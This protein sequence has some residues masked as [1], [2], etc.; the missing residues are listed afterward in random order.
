M[1]HPERKIKKKLG[2]E[3][4][5]VGARG[6]SVIDY[7]MVNDNICDRIVKFRID[8]RVNSDHMPLSL[9][10]EEGTDMGLEEDDAEQDRDEEDKD[11][12]EEEIIVWNKETIKSYI[13]NTEVINDAEDI[14][15]GRRNNEKEI[16][17]MWEELKQMVFNNVVKKKIKRKRRCIGYKDFLV[18]YKLL[19][20]EERSEENMK[21]MEK[22]KKDEKKMFGEEERELLEKKQKEKREEEEEELKKLKR[23]ADV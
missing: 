2:E 16:E 18:G 6:I 19:Q 9:I 15:K 20:E 10:L 13:K 22:W 5:Y 11:I 3:Y 21:E 23:E 8:A 14:D 17:A 7:M 4:T 1:A 12:K